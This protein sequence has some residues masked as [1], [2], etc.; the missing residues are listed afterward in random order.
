MLKS[1][2]R[3][4]VTHGIG[5]LPKVDQIIVLDEGTVVEVGTYK[6]LLR[7]KGAF[8]VV[9]SAYLIGQEE[10]EESEDEDTIAVK[11]EIKREIGELPPPFERSLSTPSQSSLRRVKRIASRQDSK[12]AL[13]KK[14]SLLSGKEDIALV[15]LDKGALVGKEKSET[16]GVAWYVS[17]SGY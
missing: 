17:V 8:S 11:E 14:A 5:Y 10:A 2:T 4:L 7:N 6:E 13:A 12:P 16:G 3:I 15:R 9:L 1:K